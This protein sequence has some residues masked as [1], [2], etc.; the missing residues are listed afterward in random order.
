M[1]LSIFVLSG[2]EIIS[3][4]IKIYNQTVVYELKYLHWIRNPH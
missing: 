1:L 3:S 4:H 2:F